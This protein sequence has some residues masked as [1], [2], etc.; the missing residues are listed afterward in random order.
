MAAASIAQ[1]RDG[2]CMQVDGDPTGVV[3]EAQPVQPI[4]PVAPTEG[5][6]STERCHERLGLDPAVV[7]MILRASMWMECMD[8]QSGCIFYHYIEQGV[9]N[10]E[11]PET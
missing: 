6:G 1:G 2:A 8:K 9:S 7:T 11:L 10:W 3:A 4:T 5:Q